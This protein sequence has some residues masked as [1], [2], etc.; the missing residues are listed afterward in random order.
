MLLVNQIVVGWW[1]AA[2]CSGLQLGL[3]LKWKVAEVLESYI[4]YLVMIVRG[5][6]RSGIWL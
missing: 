3:E 4:N 1:R 5:A 2:I 6:C